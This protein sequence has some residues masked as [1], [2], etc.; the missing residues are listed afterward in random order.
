MR[1]IGNNFV[2]VTHVDNREHRS[3]RPFCWNIACPGKEDQ[4]AIQEVYEFI[5][6]GLLT[7]QEATRTVEGKML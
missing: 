6:E 5:Q 1:R 4:I 7:V 3:N 2:P